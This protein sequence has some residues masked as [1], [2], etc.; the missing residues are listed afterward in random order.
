M[1]DIAIEQA[2]AEAGSNP[3]KKKGGRKKKLI[4]LLLVVLIGGAG[5]YYAMYGMP[6]SHGASAAEAEHA[7]EPQ[8]V[9]RDGIS[10]AAATR[11]R[12]AARTGRPDPRVFRTTYIPLEGNFTSNLRGG[13]NFVQIGL[14]LS[15]FYDDH[16]KE[17]V[18][19]N[20][21]AIRSAIIL[22]L[23]EADPVE[24]TTL[25]GKEALKEALKNAI[26]RVL[27]NREGFGGIDDVYFTSFV[28]Q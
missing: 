1:T 21:M 18:E 22:T 9:L 14:G 16:V 15:T 27:T 25:S 20:M 12:A 11:A 13:D 4:L 5:G 24:I 7:D 8:L 6:G 23:S 17:N 26:N 28:T 10:E 3:K 2:P 19:R